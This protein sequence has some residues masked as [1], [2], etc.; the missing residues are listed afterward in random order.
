VARSEDRLRTLHARGLRPVAI[1]LALNT[2]AEEVRD[3]LVAL[4]LKPNRRPTKVLAPIDYVLARLDRPAEGCWIWRGSMHRSSNQP[5]VTVGGAQFFVVRIL[6]EHLIAPG[7]RALQRT[8]DEVRCVRP[9]HR[10]EAPP[11]VRR[12]RRHR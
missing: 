12:R 9:S 2:T 7:P 1:A 5:A 11:P 6:W 4:G 10:E 3:Q 8:C